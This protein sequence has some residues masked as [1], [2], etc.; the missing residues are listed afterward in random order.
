MSA[1]RIFHITSR[2]AWVES[3]TRGHYVAPSLASEGF[4]HC[5]TQDQVLET[6]NRYY[7]GHRGLVLLYIEPERLSSRLEYEAAAPVAEGS[8]RAGLFPHVYGP[9]A[10]HALSRV[11]DFEPTRGEFE[12]PAGVDERDPRDGRSPADNLV[13]KNERIQRF[14]ADFCRCSGVPETTAYQAWYF[15]DGAELAHEL[16]D[17]VVHG[18]K[19]A[20][21]TLLW[22]I[23]RHPPL[24]PIPG[25]YSVV[26]DF[27]SRPRVVIR[28]TSVEVR[29]FDAV[30]AAFASEEGEGDRTL[31]TWR[32][33]HTEYFGRECA[34]IGKIFRSDAPVV[35]E[36][37]ERL[38]GYE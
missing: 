23:E 19:R 4:V 34:T 10:V 20:S 3:V 36:R 18:S 30:D 37:F 7:R 12:W 31:E 8:S 38:S 26:T 2:V 29:A 13:E 21:T 28:T 15:G 25:A 6:A 33:D 24:S 27:D 9:I 1:R 11:V 17:L 22:A 5:S 35:L 14:W 16:A 32:R